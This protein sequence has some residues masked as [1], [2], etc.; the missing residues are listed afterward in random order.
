M[1]CCSVCFKNT[2]MDTIRPCQYKIYWKQDGKLEQW[3]SQMMQFDMQFI[4]TQ[5]SQPRSI[6]L[7][8]F[9]L[10]SNF[11]ACTVAYAQVLTLVKFQ[12]MFPFLHMLSVEVITTRAIWSP[13]YSWRWDVAGAFISVT[14]MDRLWM[15]M[16]SGM[17]SHSCT[18]CP[19]GSINLII[20]SF[21]KMPE[22]EI[23]YVR[24]YWRFTQCLLEYHWWSAKWQPHL[25][26]YCISTHLLSTE[27]A[28]AQS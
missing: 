16:D 26:I 18:P 2:V 7:F 19:R 1:H 27:G 12:V 15:L 24:P 14:R 4:T 23:E 5:L 3:I 9:T 21:S 28:V 20:S 10:R 22:M 25:P 8:R 13:L 17:R 6:V 11:S